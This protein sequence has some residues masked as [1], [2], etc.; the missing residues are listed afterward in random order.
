MSKKIILFISFFYLCCDSE[1]QENTIEAQNFPL[2]QY[3]GNWTLNK[4][5][6]NDGINGLYYGNCSVSGTILA[7]DL[8]NQILIPA[9]CSD[10]PQFNIILDVGVNGTLH[11]FEYNNFTGN[12]Y[13]IDSVSI[14]YFDIY[15]VSGI[16]SIH[17]YYKI[18]VQNGMFI[19]QVSG[20]KIE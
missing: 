8:S 12:Q 10:N 9:A 1:Y 13:N 19:S 14:E 5:Y 18:Y 11:N 16:D 2:E 6:Y 20:K 7:Q 4:S 17:I 3:L 15:K